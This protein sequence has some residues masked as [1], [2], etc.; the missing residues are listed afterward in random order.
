MVQTALDVGCPL[1]GPICGGLAITPVPSKYLLP[2]S[3]LDTFARGSSLSPTLTT[4][5]SGYNR[6]GGAGREGPIRRPISQLVRLDPTLRASPGE[7]RGGRV[8][9]GRRGAD[10][11]SKIQG[12][13]PPTLGPTLTVFGNTNRK[14]A[15]MNSG[16]GLRTAV[17]NATLGPMLT[18]RDATSGPG[19]AT[20]AEGSPNLRTVVNGQKMAPTLCAQDSEHAPENGRN[21]AATGKQ[22]MVAH[23]IGMTQTGGSLSAEWCE[24]YMGFPIGW[25]AAFRR[26]STGHNSTGSRRASRSAKR[27]T[28]P[29]SVPPVTPSFPPSRT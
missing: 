1:C 22:I 23:A 4:E 11:M 26:L 20:T 6:G 2:S 13:F 8:Q 25:T 15:S 7:N 19:H 9:D 24:A 27:E 3:A 17:V 21:R 18:T 5:R 28:P 12:R 14:G 16:D 10:V 29:A